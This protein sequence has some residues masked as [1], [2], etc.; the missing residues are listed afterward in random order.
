MVQAIVATCDKSLLGPRDRTLSLTRY[1][2]LSTPKNVIPACLGAG[3]CGHAAAD[4]LNQ[5]PTLFGR[6]RLDTE[7]GSRKR[8][9]PHTLTPSVH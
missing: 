6:R 2:L 5:R 7:R 8:V 9:L 3:G 1:A 4:G